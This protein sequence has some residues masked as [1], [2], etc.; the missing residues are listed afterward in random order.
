MVNEN[1][2]FKLLQKLRASF[3]TDLTVQ[4]LWVIGITKGFISATLGVSK[5]LDFGE[6]LS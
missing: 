6:G 3:I 1:L 4:K 2:L 5:V